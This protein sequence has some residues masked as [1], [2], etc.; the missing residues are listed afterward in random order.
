MPNHFSFDHLPFCASQPPERNHADDALEH[1]PERR[2][3]NH[4]RRLAILD[5]L[6]ASRYAKNLT[7]T[8]S[9]KCLKNPSRRHQEHGERIFSSPAPIQ[10]RRHSHDQ[11][12]D[13]IPE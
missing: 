1:A 13:V 8:Y 7:S 4:R 12:V 6:G 3:F 5:H 11:G 9:L 2:R 10:I